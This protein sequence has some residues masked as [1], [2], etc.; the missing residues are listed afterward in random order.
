MSRDFQKPVELA[1]M[2][3]RLERALALKARLG[4]A[5]EQYDAVL[6]SIEEK[7][8]QYEAHGGELAKYDAQLESVIRDMIGTSN[9][10][11]AEP[12]AEEVR[13]TPAVPGHQNGQDG[14]PR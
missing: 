13:P 5:G 10:P 12:N 11:P 4:K 1:G 8:R 14:G 7:T 6:D 3:A 2:K 9:H